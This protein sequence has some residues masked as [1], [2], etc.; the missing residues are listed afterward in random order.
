[1]NQLQPPQLQSNHDEMISKLLGDLENYNSIIPP[2]VI[3]YY[4]RKSGVNTDDENVYVKK[5]KI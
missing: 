5:K 3:Q 4:L 1:M 2:E